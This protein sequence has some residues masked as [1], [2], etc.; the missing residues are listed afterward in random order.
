M[1]NKFVGILAVL[2]LAIGFLILNYPTLSTLYNQLHQGTVLTTYDDTVQKMNEEKKKEYWQ[3]AKAYNER[4][5]GTTPQLTDAFSNKGNKEDSDY[6]QILNLEEDTGVMGSI[7][8]PKISVYLPIYHGT[9]AEV[10]ERGVGHME[11][12]SFPIGGRSTHAVLTGHRGLPSAELFTNLDQIEE[13]DE[14]F[15]IGAMVTLRQIELHEGLN[16][17]SQ[18]AVKESVTHIVGVQFRNL[19]TV[20]G[21]IFGKFGFSDVLSCFLA[22]DSYVEL[23]HEGIIPLDQFAANKCPN[24]ILVRLII[25]KHPQESV[26]LSHR[27]T[28]TDFPVLTCAVSLGEKEAYAVVGARPSR[29][30]RVRLSDQWMEQIKD[31][32]GRKKLADEV[33][34]QMNFGS[35]MRGSAAYREQ[36]SKVLL[37]RGFEQLEERREK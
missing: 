26:Y 36:L 31:D 6:N 30:C 22:F 37:R 12:T 33:T 19:A 32:E 3:E 28:K 14:E 29:A 2:L 16:T 4:L 1:R 27:N 10:L 7:E 11:G 5:A 17:W 35:N 13:N 8:I 15:S 18:G 21:S 20:G 34:G 9:S 23:H 25:K 24:D